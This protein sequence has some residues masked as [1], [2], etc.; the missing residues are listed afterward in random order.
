MNKPLILEDW[1]LAYLQ[2]AVADSLK[3]FYHLYKEAEKSG[4]GLDAIETVIKNYEELQLKL[5]AAA[6]DEE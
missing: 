4:V 6:G 2:D 3:N 1:E 5:E